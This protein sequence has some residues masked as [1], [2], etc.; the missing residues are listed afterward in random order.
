MIGNATGYYSPLWLH[1]FASSWR[2]WTKTKNTRHLK[3]WYRYIM[4]R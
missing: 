1:V 3:F 2:N 4:G